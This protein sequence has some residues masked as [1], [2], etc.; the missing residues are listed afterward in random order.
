M[1]RG[2]SLLV[3]G[4][5][6]EGLA[7][8]RGG[9]EVAEADGAVYDALTGRIGL[10]IA[11]GSRDPAAGIVAGRTGLAEAKRLGLRSQAIAF[12]GNMA[13]DA[14][15]T[16]DW[17][18]LRAEIGSLLDGNL[19]D[20]SR[21]WL[22]SGSVVLRAWSGED[23]SES[24]SE[25]DHIWADGKD[26]GMHRVMRLGMEACVNLAAGRLAEAHARASEEARISPLNAPDALQIAGRAA[27][28]MRNGAMIAEDLAALDA[29]DV[30]GPVVILRRFALL[31]AMAALEGRTDEARS[32]YRRAFGGLVD[33]GIAFEAALVAID[34]ATVLEPGDPDGR[35]AA[36]EVR[37]VLE[38]LQARPFI[39]RLERELART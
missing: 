34:M 1:I 15:W 19:E 22:L 3:L 11:I 33:K 35:A 18:W 39:E 38:R 32:L 25:L 20:V 21:E 9:I 5:S 17:D 29:T 27:T 24:L 10:Q 16:G 13:D 8:L 37:P 6:R 28:W 26:A 12:A 14:R 7:V 2:T 31:A 36:A 4:R 30:K 23:V